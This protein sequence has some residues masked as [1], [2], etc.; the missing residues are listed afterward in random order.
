MYLMS[1]SS[2]Y[3]RNYVL[4]FRLSAVQ[5]GPIPLNQ[6]GPECL[7]S[8][9]VTGFE[10]DCAATIQTERWSIQSKRE[11]ADASS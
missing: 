7:C 9:R 5:T 8:L 2:S 3:M 1:G 10:L 11:V 4:E 6:P